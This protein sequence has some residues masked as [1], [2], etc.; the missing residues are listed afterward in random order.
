V[1][2]GPIC[3]NNLAGCADQFI[4]AKYLGDSLSL[5]PA[6]SDRC[7]LSSLGQAQ[8]RAAAKTIT[9]SALK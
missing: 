5:D 3:A 8:E 6:K 4:A 7:R 2:D 9:C 1:R